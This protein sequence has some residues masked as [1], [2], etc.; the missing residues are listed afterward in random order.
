MKI[1]HFRTIVL[2]L[3]LVSSLTWGND[4]WG[5]GKHT[6]E[7]TIKKEFMVNPTALLKVTND[8]GNLTLTSWTE[9]RIV[10]EIH[11]M[12]NGNNEE[13]VQE[14]LEEISVDFEANSDMVSARTIF[15]DRSSGWGWS[16]GRNN[17]VNMQINYVIKLPV[18]N[19]IHLDND[20]G[21]I[22]LDRIDGHAKI[23]CDYGRLEIGELR[24]RNNQLNFDYTSKSTFEYINSAEIRADYSSFQIE[25]AGDLRLL[26]DYTDAI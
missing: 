8:Y 13:R 15:K 20:Y 16:W 17:N 10:M 21:N 1:T 7:K 12:T 5:N 19:S 23:S 9:D 26:T 25:N 2:P 6:K 24:G 11:I 14:K 22:L 4:R 18:K 3:L